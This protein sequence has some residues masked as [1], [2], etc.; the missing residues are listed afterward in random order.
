MLLYSTLFLQKEKEVK[1]Q[2][3][4]Q[5]QQMVEGGMSDATLCL[6][7]GQY[8][9][10]LYLY[11]CNVVLYNACAPIR[12]WGTLKSLLQAV[13]VSCF[14]KNIMFEYNFIYIETNVVPDGCSW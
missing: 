3:K 4:Q 8:H 13:S 7:D 14:F 6:E 5:K 12:T 9:T 10:L 1:K 11:V 2:T